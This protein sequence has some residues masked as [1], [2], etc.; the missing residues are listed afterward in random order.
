M[1]PKL[2]VRSRG[3][4]EPGVAGPG[5]DDLAN[6]TPINIGETS[7]PTD[8]ASLTWDDD[9]PFAG[10]AATRSAWWKVT[11]SAGRFVHIRAT[12]DVS[13]D[14]FLCAYIAETDTPGFADLLQWGWRDDDDG[15]GASGYDPMMTSVGLAA[16]STVWIR[17]SFY[18]GGS[19]TFTLTITEQDGDLSPLRA[20]AP[21]QSDF[22]TST[23]GLNR[24]AYPRRS[25]SGAYLA[26]AGSRGEYSTRQ[27]ALHMF[28][29][30]GGALVLLDSWLGAVDPYGSS[31][32]LGDSLWLDDQTFLFV[33]RTGYSRGAGNLVLATVQSDGSVTYATRAFS[34]Q[35]APFQ[36]TAVIVGTDV[37]MAC[38]L[39]AGEAGKVTFSFAGGTFSNYS[40]TSWGLPF[41]AGNA[42]AYASRLA[43]GTIVFLRENS[44]FA[45]AVSSSGSFLGA[46][47]D[48]SAA[49][50]ADAELWKGVV[51]AGDLVWSAVSVRSG[52]SASEM[53]WCGHNPVSGA[54]EETLATGIL[55]GDPD[56]GDSVFAWRVESDRDDPQYAHFVSLN[57]SYSLIFIS[58]VDGSAKTVSSREIVGTPN[59]LGRPAI[60]VSGP[61][62]EGLVGLSGLQWVQWIAAVPAEAVQVLTSALK[63]TRRRFT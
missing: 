38:Q 22:T 20:V 45:R 11:P 3:S 52:A 41:G 44:S 57:G 19:G 31:D 63:A 48:W 43:D 36:D 5:A 16:G 10:S 35:F 7:D 29:R 40:T 30:D 28:R 6:A 8:V 62:G 34:E 2:G 18:S 15:G 25:P 46:A 49:L 39:G 1:T 37:T 17:C 21:A 32:V 58:S 13:L 42:L 60:E 24:D 14:G 4:E 9:E 54:L 27:P 26:H 55:G 47:Y 33:A 61:K 59:Y 53:L 51:G 56:N 12:C 23:S 50:P